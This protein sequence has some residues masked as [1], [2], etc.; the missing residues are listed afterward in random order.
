MKTGNDSCQLTPPSVMSYGG[1]EGRLGQTTCPLP[2]LSIVSYEEMTG[3]RVPP[4][5]HPPAPPLHVTS[6]AGC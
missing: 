3:C 4:P 1:M 6:T 2:A 5:S